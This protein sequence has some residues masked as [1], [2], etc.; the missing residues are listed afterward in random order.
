M[1][2]WHPL[3]QQLVAEG[4]LETPSASYDP[5]LLPYE[6]SLIAAI[7]CTE[8]EY[9]ELVRYAMQRQ[10]VRPAEYANIPDIQNVETIVI[11]QL[12]IG[13]LALGASILLAPKAPSVD[14]KQK[15]VGRKQLP[16]QVGPTKFNQT[17]SFDNVSSLAEY[18]E[19]VPIPFGKNGIGA[20]GEPTGG[21]IIAPALVWSR[22]LAYG[23]FQAF[24]GIYVAGQYGIETPDIG[25]I[26]NGTQAIGSLGN[27]E[28][29]LFWSSAKGGNRPGGT[30]FAGTSVGLDSGT[31]GRTPFLAPFTEEFSMTYN[32]GGDT[33]FGTSTPIHNGTAFRFNWEIV[34]APFATTEG[35]DN[36]DARQE[37]IAKRRKIA[38]NKAD[39][40]HIRESAERGQPGVGRAYARR[41]GLISHNGIP[42][43][44]KTRI[45]S[46]SAG[47]EVQFRI[48][49]NN[50]PWDNEA[51]KDVTD[52]EGG[53]GGTSINLKDLKTTADAWRQ[54]AGDLLVIGT[55]W[56]I[57][58]S[59][60]V[61][62]GISEAPQ[63]KLVTL[64]CVALLGGGGIGLAGRRNI[65]EPLGG[66]DGDQF[67]EDKHCGAA[68]F[69]LCRSNIA[70]IRPVRRD[71]VAIEFGIKSQV[72]NKAN[73][74][75]NFNAIPTA[76]QLF[77]L[78]RDDIQVNTPQMDKYFTRTSVFTV[79]VREVKPY[80]ET[81][82]Q[83]SWVELPRLFGVQ[84][85]APVDQ[86]NYLRI[87]PSIPGYYEY[88]F[89]PKNGD[90]IAVNYNDA[91]QILILNAREAEVPHTLGSGLSQTLSNSV[92]SFKVTT[93]GKIRTVAQ[94]RLN[95]EM[96][97][98]PSAGTTQ[99]VTVDEVTGVTSTGFA[100]GT[101][102]TQL[103]RFAYYSQIFGERAHRLPVGTQRRARLTRFRQN[104]QKEIA[105]DAI[106]TVVNEP[107]LVSPTYR[108]MVGST[109]S[110]RVRYEVVSATYDENNPN[111]APWFNG[112]QFSVGVTVNNVFS[113][114]QSAVNGVQ[115]Y[116]SYSFQEVVAAFRVTVEPRTEEI[117]VTPAGN[118]RLFEQN[119][120]LA[121]RS[122]YEELVKS[123]ESNPEHS[124]VYV[125]EY[126]PNPSDQPTQYSDLSVLGVSIKSSGQLS[127]LNQFRIWSAEGIAVQRLIEG[128][129][130]PSNLFADLVN[131]LL[132]NNEQG[133]GN[134]VPGE[135]VDTD[136]LTTT[137]RFLRAN[138]IFYDGVIEDSENLRS[139]LYDNAI[140]QFCNFTIK[141][142]RFGMVPALPYN[143]SYEIDAVNPIA[144][145]QI[146]TAGNIIEGSL[147]LQ[148][149][150]SS[151]RTNFRGI[152]SWRQTVEND[153]PDTRT[154]LVDWSDIPE[155]S[156]IATEQSF[157]L[158]DFCTNREQALKTAR[159]LLSVR[160]R[161]THTLGFKTTPDTLGIQPGSY[162]KVVTEATT[163]NSA[164]NGAVTDAGTLAS[165]T[166]IA[167]GTYDALVYDP[168]T[169]EVLERPITIS[170][171]SV[172]DTALY[173]TLFT[174]LDTQQN[175]G[176]YQVEQLTL[177][178]DGLVNVNAVMVPVDASGVSIVAK[179]VLTPSN[180]TYAE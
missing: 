122:H 96:T 163:Y 78:D 110:W 158:T 139:F 142:G 100:V 130:A 153:L 9:K 121:D 141:N 16:N 154:A 146:F 88:R 39:V 66:Y 162:I 50:A 17:T 177:D 53:F 70:T 63:N 11:V 30:P 169:S 43:D 103:I 49:F 115:Y 135:L 71:A 140:L 21:L 62:T 178:Q 180:F 72:W 164:A 33:D 108:N 36:F 93:T 114:G 77:K 40:L 170:A 57:G 156:R 76:A 104:G 143:A 98:D 41:M 12:V 159:Y 23:G 34:S 26:L 87:R 4:G 97:T 46:V 149:I 69:A 25:G 32:P 24:E 59:E 90:D 137:A 125:N 22:L 61:V 86:F 179:D 152:V 150:E 3:H 82:G 92:G 81:V 112:E 127:S 1:A 44:D 134:L 54:R 171:N 175:Q 73:G 75:C 116:P 2:E 27:R 173:G 45:P 85:N 118:A 148:Y 101:G 166:T 94:C 174:I 113:G 15:K 79:W 47:D 124:I 28:Y 109:L 95:P 133:V 58:A 19:P 131:Y 5:P 129:N 31:S 74:L 20:D 8:E 123:N 83:N 106:G 80:G 10:Q 132:T 167:D 37:V 89:I 99:T 138:R 120:Q 48:D 151:Q 172:T 14:D 161:V 38:G 126:L 68:F 160:R 29:A 102:A 155:S 52:P 60:W 147:E 119:S 128:N 13:L 117:V 144:V 91:D 111:S 168:A 6:K 107:A 165:V 7:G 65:E 145:D 105:F 64:K 176:V 157:D 51:A 56:L 42:Y 67:G 84:G 136:S 35:E 18:G 55:N